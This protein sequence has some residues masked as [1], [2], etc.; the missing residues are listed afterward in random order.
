MCGGELTST[1]VRA[2][3][4]RGGFTLIEMM[5]VVVLIG[6][7]SSMAVSSF[8]SFV[9]DQD[10]TSSAR[11]VESMFSLARSESIRSGNIYIAM[12]GTDPSGAT[13]LDPNGEPVGALMFDDG[14]P[15]SANQNCAIDGG[16]IRVGFSIASGS[17][18]GLAGSAAQLVT[19]TGEGDITSGSSFVDADGD[20]ATWVMFRPE[21]TVVAFS[22]DCATGSPGSG[23]GAIYLT[24]GDR[25]AAV[26]MTPLG[27]SRVHSWAGSWTR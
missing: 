17:N 25:N 23:G 5:I 3:R 16:E 18:L 21:G 15:G 10:L 20:P 13:L 12:V 27:S 9:G 22:A 24:D 1:E 6:V 14:R 19:D 2:T 7:V 26:V 4:S 8:S 11:S